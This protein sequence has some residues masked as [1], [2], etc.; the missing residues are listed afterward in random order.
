MKHTKSSKNNISIGSA[1][2]AEAERKIAEAKKRGVAVF[3]GGYNN[4]VDFSKPKI[5]MDF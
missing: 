1:I 5:K 3:C 2:V 4:I